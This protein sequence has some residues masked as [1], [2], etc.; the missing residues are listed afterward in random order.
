SSGVP[1]RL[2][3]PVMPHMLVRLFRGATP[4]EHAHARDAAPHRLL[5]A[6]AALSQIAR[7][8]EPAVAAAYPA[9]FRDVELGAELGLEVPEPHE[10]EGL[11]ARGHRPRHDRPRKQLGG[12]VPAVRGAMGPGPQQQLP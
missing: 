7:P 10:V 12:P 1:W 5:P 11:A 4:A 6:I 3:S 2:N 8:R 9:V